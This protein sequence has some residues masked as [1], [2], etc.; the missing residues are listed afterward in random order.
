MYQIDDQSDLI[1]K[2]APVITLTDSSINDRQDPYNDVATITVIIAA[3]VQRLPHNGL[4]LHQT[5]G[6]PLSHKSDAICCR[7]IIR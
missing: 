1:I 3:S 4:Y 7:F 2:K 5:L 6:L